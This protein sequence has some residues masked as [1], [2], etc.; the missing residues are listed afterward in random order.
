LLAGAEHFDDDAVLDHQT[1]SCIEV[2]GGENSEGIFQPDTDRGH[3]AG[4]SENRVQ[5]RQLSVALSADPGS[6][7]RCSGEGGILTGFWVYAKSLWEILCWPAMHFLVGPALAGKAAFQAINFG[8][9]YWP[10]PG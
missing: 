4:S 2:V 9:V 5:V 8:R 10:L 6:P 1:A 7:V 3:F